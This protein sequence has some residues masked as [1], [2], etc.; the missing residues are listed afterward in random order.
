MA[1][2][3]KDGETLSAHGVDI[4]GD[5]QGNQ[6]ILVLV[7]FEKLDRYTRFATITGYIFIDSDAKSKGYAGKFS[8][9]NFDIQGD[10]FDNYLAMGPKEDETDSP[11]FC[12][13]RCYEF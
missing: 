10:D 13:H 9:M 4:V 5:G 11:F 8:E 3:L 1:K 2:F 6:G 7:G 12:L